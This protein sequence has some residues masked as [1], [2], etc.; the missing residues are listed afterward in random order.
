MSAIS[1][2]SKRFLSA[3]RGRESPWHLSEVRTIWRRVVE[4]VE[5]VE[6]LL[7]GSL[8]L[9]ELHVV[10]DE[11]STRRK[12]SLKSLMRSRR[13]EAMRSFM[14]ASE[15]RYDTNQRLAFEYLVAMAFT[16]W[17]C[18]D[19]AAVDERR[20]VVVAGWCRDCLARRMRELVRGADDEIARCYLGLSVA[21]TA[22]SRR[23]AGARRIGEE[24]S[25]VAH[26]RSISTGVVRR[27]S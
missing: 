15:E 5:R 26:G 16:R 27:R 1:P 23:S 25:L 7:L 8:R 19:R 10:Q 14:N 17:F 18:Q 9:P 21:W 6:E 4:R 2:H 20:V 3:P 24:L 11:T 13:S 12:R 22:R